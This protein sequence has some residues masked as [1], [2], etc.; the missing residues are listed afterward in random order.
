MPLSKEQ[1]EIVNAKTSNIIVDAG[2]GSGKTTVLK[3]RVIHLLKDEGYHLDEMIILTF[4]DLAAKEIKDKIIS[5]LNEA[6]SLKDDPVLRDELDHIDEAM[7][8]T[9][10][11]FCHDIVRKYACYSEISPS[12]Q[13]GDEAL[14]G[15]K[16]HEFLDEI[17]S[18]YF[19]D[20]SPAF[21]TFI[22]YF[23]ANNPRAII[24][25]F[26]DLN[27]QVNAIYDSNGFLEHYDSNFF[28]EG[29]VNFVLESFI[30]EI[31]GKLDFLSRFDIEAPADY[32][33]PFVDQIHLIIDNI[34]SIDDFGKMIDAIKVSQ[35]PRLPSS[36]GKEE[37]D[38]DSKKEFDN[39]RD[40]IKKGLKE[41][42]EA[43]KKFTGPE[44][45]KEAYTAYREPSKIVSAVLLSLNNKLNDFKKEQAIYS[46]LD[47]EKEAIRLLLAHPEIS[48]YYKS[49]IKEI[50]IDEYQDTNDLNSLLI[51]LISNNNEVVVGD[52]KQS[53]Y[54]FRNAKPDIFLKR[55]SDY[56]KFKT[57]TVYELM[58]NYRSRKAEVLDPVNNA[59]KNIAKEPYIDI[60]YF[61]R[62][63]KY[64]YTDYDFDDDAKNSF[65]IIEADPHADPYSVIASDVKKRMEEGQLK[66]TKEGQV[67]ANFSDF[68]LLT[69]S[70]DSCEK[71]RKAFE[72]YGIPTKI[73]GNEPF[74]DFEEI[75]LIKNVLKVVNDF[76]QN[77]VNTNPLFNLNLSAVLRSFSFNATDNMVAKYIL[78]SRTLGNLE[79][80][81]KNFPILFD[82]F[83]SYVIVLHSLGAYEM[84]NNIYH[85]FQIYE[86]LSRLNKPEERELKLNTLLASF[87]TMAQSGLSLKDLI[88]Y[89][90]YLRKNDIDLSEKLNEMEDLPCVRI[91]TIHKSKG[92]EAPFVYVFDLSKRRTNHKM[93]FSPVFGFNFNGA[94]S[95]SGFVMTKIQSREDRKEQLSLAYVAMT[96]AKESLTLVFDGKHRSYREGVEKANTI[97]KLLLL[98]NEFSDDAYV[99]PIP[100]PIEP[101]NPAS[102][103]RSNKVNL[104]YQEIH[105]EKPVAIERI[106]ASHEVIT[107][108]EEVSAALN[109]GNELH[110]YFERAD[111]LHDTYVDFTNK[112]IP[113]NDQSFLMNF[114]ASS[115]F[116][117]PSLREF[118]ELPFFIDGTHGIMDYV[119]EKDDHF[120][121]VDF[122]TSSLDDPLYVNQLYTYLEYLKKRTTKP[123]ELYLYSILKNELRRIK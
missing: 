3:A 95:P 47:I 64:G 28:N 103:S 16:S 56:Q 112:G 43:V 81:K 63:L 5:A 10:D 61:S 74:I 2:A 21:E 65:K 48:A 37:I 42:R 117:T 6:L 29:Q 67:K 68:L 60:E 39:R 115:L 31:K 96:R 1:L 59:F 22:N 119:L 36:K 80:L 55:E 101:F 120:V 70:T 45:I 105:L 76:D 33:E 32:L 100:D 27:K 121:I 71:L 25:Y 52:V 49:H 12:F 113:E 108:S 69:Y 114:K 11:S 106:K 88:A 79:A 35:M 75:I 17:L 111:F 118:H 26:L 41:I 9:F 93:I 24:D 91:M 30:K 40:I 18:P 107:L 51:S 123:I 50:I 83:T 46:F 8:E 89:F 62:L 98:N 14:F 20:P 78:E 90:D 57:G 104:N 23:Q 38:P 58:T 102:N 19:K 94:D 92:L 13:I 110:S 122:K 85:D 53:I 44:S 66:H 15:M 34:L 87:K 77:S 116:R 4:T 7:I 97:E 109:R 86:N 54:R 84:I 73:Y 99:N 72:R 82:R